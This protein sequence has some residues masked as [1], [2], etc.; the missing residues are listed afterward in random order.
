MTEK[1]A[2]DK[3]QK[4]FAFGIIGTGVLAMALSLLTKTNILPVI[5][6]L[7][8]AGLWFVCGVLLT[9]GMRKLSGVK[10]KIEF[11]EGTGALVFVCIGVL[12]IVSLFL[13]RSVMVIVLIGILFVVGSLLPLTKLATREKRDNWVTVLFGAVPF[14]PL[15][16]LHGN[17]T[18]VMSML[19]FLGAVMIITGY[20]FLLTDFNNQRFIRRRA[21]ILLR[22][23][24]L[25]TF[26]FLGVVWPY[27]TG[28]YQGELAKDN[29]PSEKFGISTPQSA[30]DYK[31][32]IWNEGHYVL[33][34]FKALKTE[35][36][37]WQATHPLG[38]DAY[39]NGFTFE[40]AKAAEAKLETLDRDGRDELRYND[41]S[42]TMDEA[43]IRETQTLYPLWWPRDISKEM[44]Y[45]IIIEHFWL[46][47]VYIEPDDEGWVKVYFFCRYNPEFAFR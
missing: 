35:V 3:T 18:A 44:R 29:F 12:V 2:M 9:V 17:G 6:L 25:I 45:D 22:F 11:S 27:E 7:I 36:R 1:I 31:L 21:Q 39:D 23:A 47:I 20:I 32:R 5:H 8:S 42:T 46:A 19:I 38:L 28:D 40:D 4:G 30:E 34:S 15:S 37:Q 24:M 41:E 14:I 16:R 13:K 26:T 43:I 33:F 10:G